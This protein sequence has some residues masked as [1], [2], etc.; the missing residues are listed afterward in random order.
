MQKCFAVPFVAGEHLDKLKSL[1]SPPKGSAQLRDGAP[2]PQ[3]LMDFTQI[4]KNIFRS[5]PLKLMLNA[6]PFQDGSSDCKPVPIAPELM[7]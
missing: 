2:E 5:F 3:H 4:H 1:P 6:I 7:Y